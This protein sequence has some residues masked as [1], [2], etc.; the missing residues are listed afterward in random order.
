MVKITINQGVIV[1]LQLMRES[2]VKE[3]G[4]SLEGL[5]AKQ[6]RQRPLVNEVE[7]MDLRSGTGTVTWNKIESKI[8]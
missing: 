7:S 1:E 2:T 6:S 5:E 3:S 8:E 4:V